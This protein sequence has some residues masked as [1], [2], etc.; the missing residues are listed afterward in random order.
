VL[1]LWNGEEYKVLSHPF[2]LSWPLTPGRHRFQAVIPGTNFKS[3]EIHIEVFEMMV[4]RP[5]IS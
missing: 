3:R 2:S 5:P 1:W 4:E